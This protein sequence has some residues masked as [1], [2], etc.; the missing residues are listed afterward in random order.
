MKKALIAAAALAVIGGAVFAEGKNCAGE[1]A[2][3]GIATTAITGNPVA[4]GAA[5]ATD[6]VICKTTK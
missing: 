2:V 6:Y 5:A 1:A 3:V 4:G